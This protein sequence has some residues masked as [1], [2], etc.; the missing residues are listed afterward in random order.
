MMLGF[1]CSRKQARHMLHASRTSAR[2]AVGVVDE[3]PV[4]KVHEREGA[5]V[6][7]L[8]RVQPAGQLI[9]GLQRR[10]IHPQHC[11]GLEGDHL[12]CM[13]S[14]AC[15]SSPR[16]LMK[17]ACCFPQWAAKRTLWCCDRC[18]SKNMSI[19]VQPYLLQSLPRG[20]LHPVCPIWE[21]GS[22]PHL[23]HMTL[24]TLICLASFDT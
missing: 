8:W 10:P 17:D 22:A 13:T 14:A 12:S 19:G 16:V 23:G 9:V 7:L 21:A 24:T 1:Y 5:S 3:I 2:I 18:Y 11:V 15:T 4:H 6:Q 20:F